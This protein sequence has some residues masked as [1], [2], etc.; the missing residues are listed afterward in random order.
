MHLRRSPN[1][2]F[3]LCTWTKT[4]NYDRQPAGPSVSPQALQL[5]SHFQFHQVIGF[6]FHVY[7]T[8]SNSPLSGALAAYS[9]H[10]IALRLVLWQ[11]SS[12]APGEKFGVAAK[13]A[14]EDIGTRTVHVHR[15]TF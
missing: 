13:P 9:T 5:S 15:S 1:F 14:D 11:P 4:C 3:L 8:I 6:L 10:H 7:S 2:H 12:L